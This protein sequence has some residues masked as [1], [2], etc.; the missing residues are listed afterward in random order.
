MEKRKLI[1]YFNTAFYI[2]NENCVKTFLKL[3]INDYL[4]GAR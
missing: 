2:S 4:K 3:F 1:N